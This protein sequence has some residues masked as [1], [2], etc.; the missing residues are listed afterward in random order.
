[1]LAEMV[2]I[3]A[4]FADAD[5]PLPGEPVSALRAFSEDW[6]SELT[7]FRQARPQTSS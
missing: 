6:H 3:L 5:I 1:V 7:A 4:R 2:S